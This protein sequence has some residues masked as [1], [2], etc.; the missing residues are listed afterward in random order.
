MRWLS[1]ETIGERDEQHSFNGEVVA[2]AV[3]IED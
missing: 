3:E 1:D 2:L